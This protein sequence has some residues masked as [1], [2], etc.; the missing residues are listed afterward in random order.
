MIHVTIAFYVLCI[1]FGSEDFED[2]FSYS[3]M[4]LS[5]KFFKVLFLFI[6]N[7][8]DFNSIHVLVHCIVQ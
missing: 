7:K 5:A 2:T 1:R 8:F 4:F 3:G 6:Y